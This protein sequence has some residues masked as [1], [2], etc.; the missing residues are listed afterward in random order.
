MAVSSTFTAGSG[1]G[2]DR[3]MGRWSA[4]LAEA[5][6][7]FAGCGRR[8]GCSGCR[9][10]DRQSDVGPFAAHQCAQ[11]HRRRLLADLHRLREP[12]HSRS[13]NHLQG[14]RH[15]RAAVRRSS[16][17]IAC[18]RCWCCISCRRPNAP[19]RSCAVSPV[20]ARPSR[21]RSGTCAVVMSPIGMFYDTA[22]AFDDEGRRRRAHN[23]TR[24]MTRPGEL[25]AAWRAAGL[26]RRA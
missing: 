26:H 19:S 23:Y 7:D 24:P 3:I 18:S 1:E 9:L 16:A 11:H 5:F 6:L 8:R 2:Y 17:S 21:P 25:A 10:R 4:R 15:L 12:G 22:A 20:R 13:A 14:W